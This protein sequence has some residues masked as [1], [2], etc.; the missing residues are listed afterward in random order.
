[1]IHIIRPAVHVKLTVEQ[2]KKKPS[3]YGS[4][5]SYTPASDECAAPFVPAADNYTPPP[6]DPAPS[7]DSGGGSFDGG[8][9]SFDGGGASGDY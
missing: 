7:C 2:G 4:S 9:G 3:P 8:G 5:S 6:A 1:M